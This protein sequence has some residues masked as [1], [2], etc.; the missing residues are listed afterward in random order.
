MST[1]EAAKPM[2][3][4]GWDFESIITL[5]NGQ[6]NGNI[7]F[8][9]YMPSRDTTKINDIIMTDAEVKKVVNKGV[10]IKYVSLIGGP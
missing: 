10:V 5:K 2:H 6:F 3:A 4:N 1:Q 9:I 8:P 7:N